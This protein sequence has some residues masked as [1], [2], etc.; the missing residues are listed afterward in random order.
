MRMY[1]PASVPGAVRIRSAKLN[2]PRPFVFLRLVEAM[3]PPEVMRLNYG[4]CLLPR[5]A[6]ET[7]YLSYKKIISIDRSRGFP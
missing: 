4:V 6:G 3:T 5:S 7:I 2:F 1:R